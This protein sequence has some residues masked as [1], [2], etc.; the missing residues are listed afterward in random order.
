M[1]CI[2][3]SRLLFGSL[4]SGNRTFDSDRGINW[5]SC[6]HIFFFFSKINDRAKPGAHE[7]YGI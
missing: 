4:E 7:N 2:F 3:A 1:T 5:S 6:G